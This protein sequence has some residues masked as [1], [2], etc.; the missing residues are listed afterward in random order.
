MWQH[1]GQHTRLTF[2]SFS[3]VTTWL[4]EHCWKSRFPLK[5]LSEIRMWKQAVEM[6]ALDKGHWSCAL[7][8]TPGERGHPKHLQVLWYCFERH[9]ITLFPSSTEIIM[10]KFLELLH[11][12][13]KCCTQ[14][15]PSLLQIYRPLW[16]RRLLE[17]HQ[18]ITP[19]K[20]KGWRDEQRKT[21]WRLQA[22][23]LVE[24]PMP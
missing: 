2:N 16:Y 19:C 9:K 5:C 6:A 13:N 22:E 14:S 10:S 7:Q 18:P 8:G 11:Q 3:S 17:I 21:K 12:T 15:S 4:T 24:H 1:L 20:Y 23:R